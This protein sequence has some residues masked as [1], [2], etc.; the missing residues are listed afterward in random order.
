MTAD[1]KR[2][3]VQYG[4]SGGFIRGPLGLLE[5]LF[6]ELD[7]Q[8]EVTSGTGPR[9]RPYG[10]RQRS[11]SAAGQPIKIRLDD[12]EVYTVRTTSVQKTFIKEVI[13]AAGIKV[14]EIW[15]ER[16]TIYGK[17]VAESQ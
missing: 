8:W 1:P 15:S 14:V 2:R 16:G 12:G 13:R 9:R 5:Y 6:G 4:F 7:L 11:N 3:L 10:S 17:K